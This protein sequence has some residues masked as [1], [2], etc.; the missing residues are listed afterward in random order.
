MSI[1]IDKLD[2]VKEF[3]KQHNYLPE[4]HQIDDYSC[5]F[6]LPFPKEEII[7][8]Y[9][10][11]A[12][13]IHMNNVVVPLIEAGYRLGIYLDI[14]NRLKRNDILPATLVYYKTDGTKVDK[15]SELLKPPE[16]IKEEMNLAKIAANV[17]NK[18]ESLS[19]RHE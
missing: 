7:Y 5:K 11:L 10:T 17:V 1:E 3:L 6:I 8:K 9:D 14:T 4:V 13:N 18:K 16:D 2:E 15:L 12:G 19:I